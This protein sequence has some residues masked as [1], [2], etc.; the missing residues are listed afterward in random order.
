MSHR[1]VESVMAMGI[2]SNLR[3]VSEGEENRW[4]ISGSSAIAAAMEQKLRMGYVVSDSA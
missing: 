4:E 3:E 1:I 2:A